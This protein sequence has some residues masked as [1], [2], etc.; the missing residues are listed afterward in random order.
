M[1]SLI[2]AATTG[3]MRMHAG[4]GVILALAVVAAKL[5]HFPSLS[6]SCRTLPALPVLLLLY[7]ACVVLLWPTVI[8][9]PVAIIVCA[10]L[11]PGTV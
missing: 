11:E 2:L 3:C 10:D 5:H 7:L 9:R 8:H 6:I 4:E 1:G